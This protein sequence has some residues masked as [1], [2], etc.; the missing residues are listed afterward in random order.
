MNFQANAAGNDDGPQA[1][2]EVP[3]E[4]ALT[5]SAVE[6]EESPGAEEWQTGLDAGQ[7]LTEAFDKADLAQTLKSKMTLKKSGA[8]AGNTKVSRQNSEKVLKDLFD[9]PVEGAYR[10]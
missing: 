2:K 8:A 3:E 7:C 10:I 5:K 4:D 6:E 9:N 1:V